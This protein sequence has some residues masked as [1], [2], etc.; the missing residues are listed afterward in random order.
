MTTTHQSPASG[1]TAFDELAQIVRDTWPTD[2]S[3]DDRRALQ[4]VYAATADTSVANPGL[5]HEAFLNRLPGAWVER[6]DNG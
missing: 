5:G 2:L 1:V 6:D 4:A 3:T